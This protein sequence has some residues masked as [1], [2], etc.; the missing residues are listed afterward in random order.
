MRS[1]AWRRAQ[2]E[3]IRSK[4]LD[5]M[6]LWYRRLNVPYQDNHQQIGRMIST[7]CHPCNCWLCD[8]HK[9]K[10]EY[11]D[12]ELSLMEQEINSDG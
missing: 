12:K 5:I 6:R 7:H 4:V 2:Y 9:R 8:P 3:R 10:H 11:R 1:R